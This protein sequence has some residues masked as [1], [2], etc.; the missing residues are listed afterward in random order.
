[1]LCYQLKAPLLC[2][3]S[4]VEEIDK[5][6]GESL[7]GGTHSTA[8]LAAEVLGGNKAGSSSDNDRVFHFL[9]DGA[10]FLIGGND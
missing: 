8:W 7:F 4:L 3:I 1:V 10:V 2:S 6:V 9:S 5:M